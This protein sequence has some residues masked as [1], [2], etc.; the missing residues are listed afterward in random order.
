MAGQGIQDIPNKL[1]PRNG[2]ELKIEDI[3]MWVFV[4]YDEC[5]NETELNK[6]RVTGL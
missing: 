1:F 2:Y 5:E 4:F 6:T 3:S